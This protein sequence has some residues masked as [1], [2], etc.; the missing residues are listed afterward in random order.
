MTKKDTQTV[1]SLPAPP[2]PLLP[3]TIAFM[4]GIV[5]AHFLKFPAYFFPI[6]FISLIIIFNIFRGLKKLPVLR[7]WVVI[8]LF[9]S[10]GSLRLQSFEHA[11]VDHIKNFQIPTKTGVVV[12]I[13]GTVSSDVQERIRSGTGNYSLLSASFLLEA[14]RLTA[15]DMAA[16]VSG[17][18][19]V[20]TYNFLPGLDYGD[21]VELLG[22]IYAARPPTNPGQFNYPAYLARQGIHKILRV[23]KPD[24]V[25]LLSSG[26]GNFFLMRI[27]KLRK[28]L[29]GKLNDN[30]TSAESVFLNA[31]LLGQRG[32]V[33]AELESK[34]MKSGTIHFLAVSG[35]HVGIVIAIFLLLFWLVGI[36]GYARPII[37]MMVVIFYA[38][39]TGFHIPVV[40]A[41]VMTLSFF[42]AELVKRKREPINSLSLAALV[43]VLWNP[44]EVL[45]AGFQLSFLAVL[46]IL[47]L[48]GTFRRIMPEENQALMDLIPRSWMGKAGRWAKL[49]CYNALAISLAA[50]AGVAPIVLKYFNILTPGTILSNILMAPLIFAILVVGLLNLPLLVLGISFPLTDIT[51]GLIKVVELLIEGVLKIPGSHFFFPDIPLWF[52][53]V[54]YG[55]LLSWVCRERIFS[56]S[57]GQRR[58]SL[59]LQSYKYLLLTL[60][61]S[62][63]IFIGWY[64]WLVIQP[65]KNEEL[66]L[67]ML[68]V[69]QG[70]SFL[71][72]FPDGKNCLYDAGS[73][74]F[75]DVGRNIISQYLWHEGI[76]K[77]DTLIL[78]H[79]HMDHI[80]G[81]PSL[82]ERF[83]VGQV[84]VP[85][86]F[87]NLPNGQS[88]L[89]IIENYQIP[90]RELDRGRE[91]LLATGLVG[92]V[93]SP[94]RFEKPDQAAK[95]NDF[96]LVMK[97]DYQGHTIIFTGDIEK[98]G[99]EWL[100]RSG[101]DLSATV[102]EVPHHGYHGV[103]SSELIKIMK[104]AYLLINANGTNVSDEIIQ[105][106]QSIGARILTSY[107][108]GAVTIRFLPDRVEVDSF[109]K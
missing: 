93:L 98:K 94:P 90:V 85:A 106:G 44:T 17:H 26:Q 99:I 19:K 57:I 2:R 92:Q 87:R 31:L 29:S 49:Y 42:G 66:K 25:K 108:D 22:V 73:T 32:G 54:Y 15:G 35:L 62:V 1:S 96:S 78:S 27:A 34:L 47:L 55:L 72:E 40:R 60:G 70:A 50:W 36:R 11:P 89:E 4:L 91:I 71:V 75:F 97:I 9:L 105:A 59:N 69:H 3:V 37:I 56:F 52:L 30:F 45:A 77:I 33:S 63:T 67:T 38:A 7:F 24:D 43:I 39:L 84:A 5:A 83:Q 53:L 48:T 86:Y 102:L 109:I 14:E 100:T 88:L 18:L 80:Q 10:A 6:V 103:T 23:T 65:L 16:P 64:I 12:R 79:P 8:L 68:D 61:C 46:A 74:G 41:A 20:N 76:T 13:I 104:P 107:D 95:E 58:R 82:L 101:V 51:A 28:Y 21:R 81:V